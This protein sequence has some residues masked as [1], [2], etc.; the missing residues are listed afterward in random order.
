MKTIISRFYHR[1][2]GT[3]ALGSEA[4]KQ[5]EEILKAAG[6]DVSKYIDKPTPEVTAAA[7]QAKK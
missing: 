5:H 6:M 2:I 1:K 4:T 7:K 3:V